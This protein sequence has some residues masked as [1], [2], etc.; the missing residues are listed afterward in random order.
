MRYN[1]QDLINY[2]QQESLLI[3]NIPIEMVD[4]IP[5]IITSIDK[6]LK[7]REMC[8]DA[9]LSNDEYLHICDALV[10]RCSERLDRLEKELYALV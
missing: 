3:D 7:L 1:K 10:L 9:G 5:E 8:T 6:D 2:I 4:R